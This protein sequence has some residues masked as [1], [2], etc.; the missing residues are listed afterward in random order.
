[1]LACWLVGLDGTDGRVYVVVTSQ[2]NQCG[3][4]EFRFYPN[5]TGKALSILLATKIAGK[6]VRIDSIDSSDPNSVNRVYI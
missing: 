2:Q 5:N 3:M 4:S 1:M 6:K